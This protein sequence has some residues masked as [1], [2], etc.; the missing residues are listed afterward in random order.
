MRS[1]GHDANAFRGGFKDLQA[2][3]FTEKDLERVRP[4]HTGGLTT[5]KLNERLVRQG[6]WQV[7]DGG[8]R[9]MRVAFMHS[10][11]GEACGNE[12]HTGGDH[13]AQNERGTGS[14]EAQDEQKRERGGF[15][16]RHEAKVW[17]RGSS[18]F[19]I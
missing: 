16:R 14:Q 11:E 18:G 10:G 2:S 12:P 17:C 7:G 6:S 15:H 1:H 8:A 9:L 4:R 5:P 13:E 19:A 3:S